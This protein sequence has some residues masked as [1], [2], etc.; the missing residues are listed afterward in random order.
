MKHVV[1]GVGWT[2]KLLRV[3]LLI[4]FDLKSAPMDD[5]VS[6]SDI[7]LRVAKKEK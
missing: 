4:E 5:G 2:E 1:R 7:G 6:L 3:K